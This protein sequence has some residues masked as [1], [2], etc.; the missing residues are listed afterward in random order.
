MLPVRQLMELQLRRYIEYIRNSL[1]NTIAHDRII[2]R[3]T[4]YLQIYQS[5]QIK[6]TVNI[7]FHSMELNMS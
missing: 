5:I 3:Y 6:G 2:M 7:R 4:K 1:M